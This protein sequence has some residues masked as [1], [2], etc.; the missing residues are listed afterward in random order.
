MTVSAPRVL[1]SAYQCGP[2]MGSVSQIGWH[3]Y[4]R[5]AQRVPTTLITHVRNREAL[6]AAG[7]P[8]ADSEIIYI[9]TEWFAAPLY[10]IASKLFPNSEHSVFLLSSLD[11]YVYDWAAVK[12]LKLLQKQG[13][14][15]D[16]I[17]AVTPVSPTA[18]TRLYTLQRPLI[19]GPWNGGLNNPAHFP[20][21]MRQDSGWLYSIRHLGTLID[22]ILGTTRHAAAILTAT[23]ATINSLSKSAQQRCQAVLENGV[24]LSIFTPAPYPAKPSETQPLEIIFVA[25]LL[26]FKGLPMLLHAMAAVKFPIHLTVVGE[27]PLL[28]DW[29]ALAQ[30]LGISEQIT[31]FGKGSP[32]QVVSCLHAAHVLCL[33]SVRESGGAVLLEAMAC[34]RPVIA[35]NFGGPAE[36]V[37]DAVGKLLPATGMKEVVQ[38]LIKTLENLVVEPEVWAQRGQVGRERAEQR[39]GWDAKI[40]QTIAL[41]QQVIARH[42]R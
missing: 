16:V 32:Q 34:A 27:G 25:R 26:P 14:D 30:E 24:D 39:Y 41:Y 38:E 42:V 20:E 18:A 31:W 11:F 1:L 21:I 22:K 6:T 40:E 17:H 19:V 28:H 8:L 15:W 13:Q 3:W 33:P 9:D 36:I 2:N 37:D 35:V 29:Q 5:L 12:Q 7:A 10:K 23:Q 4:S